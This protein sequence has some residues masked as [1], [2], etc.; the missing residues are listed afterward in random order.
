MVQ[1]QMHGVMML[2][3]AITMIQI[4]VLVSA[5]QEPAVT[6]NNCSCHHETSNNGHGH[7]SDDL[8]Q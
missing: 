6:G 2:Y 7:A 8:I 3:I 5:G 1:K 4:H